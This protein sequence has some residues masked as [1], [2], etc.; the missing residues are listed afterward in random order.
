MTKTEEVAKKFVQAQSRQEI[1]EIFDDCCSQY[2][3]HSA[4]SDL[5]RKVQSL[6]KG[7]F[8]SSLA[9]DLPS[10][11]K[12]RAPVRVHYA[13]YLLRTKARELREKVD[14]AHTQKREARQAEGKSRPP[15][16]FM[17][18]YD[19]AVNFLVNGDWKAKTI[20]VRLFTGRRAGEVLYRSSFVEYGEYAVK[21]TYLSKVPFE[22]QSSSAVIPTLIPAREVVDLISDLREEWH[23]DMPQHWQTYM[24]VLSEKGRKEAGEAIKAHVQNPVVAFFNNSVRPLFPELGLEDDEAGAHSLRGV[25]GCVLYRLMGG[26]DSEFSEEYMQKALVHVSGDTTSKYRKYPLTNFQLL[27]RHPGL[28]T[29]LKLKEIGWIENETPI[30]AFSIDSLTAQ[31]SDEQMLAKILTAIGSETPEDLGTF[32]G[33]LIEQ[34]LQAR[35]IASQ[36]YD[37]KPIKP[38]DIKNAS[39]K[40]TTSSKGARR[41]EAIIDAILATGEKEGVILVPTQTLVSEIHS[42]LYGTKANPTTW[43]AVRDLEKYQEALQRMGVTRNDHLEGDT[44]ESLIQEI[45]TQHGEPLQL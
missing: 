43:K 8:D 34:G 33:G 17:K 21:V 32:L 13:E 37:R 10:G 3:G 22:Q 11:S 23:L 28:E 44:M 26:H 1:E 36:A 38:D 5:A 35:K 24:D 39:Y 30:A 31:I 9:E 4:L 7:E 2:N 19:F 41:I 12:G 25:Y 45:L 20:A 40:G 42:R 6:H 18:L 14:R 15:I 29:M 27:E 16:D